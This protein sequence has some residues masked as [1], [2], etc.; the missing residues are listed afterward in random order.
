MA[1]LIGISVIATACGARVAPYLPQGGAGPA[2]LTSD[3]TTTGDGTVTTGGG[4]PNLSTGGGPGGGSTGTGSG[5]TGSTTTT[6]GN[7]GSNTNTNTNTNTNSKPPS[8]IA[9]LTPQNFNFDPQAEA[10][11]CQGTSGNKASDTGIT[12]TSITLGNVSGITGAV[13]GVFEPAVQ[14]VTAAVNAVNHF[15]GIC[16]RKII[17]NIQDDQQSASTHSS[18]IEYLIPKVFAFLGSTSDGDNGGVPAMVKAGIPD[19]GRN[20]NTNRGNAPTFWSAD[21]GSV[22]VRNGR[23]FLYNTLVTGLKKYH[24]MPS[25]M[26]FIAY[27]IPIAAQVAE[28]YAVLFN[29]AGVKTCYTNYSVPPAPGATMGSVVASMKSKGCGGVFVVMDTVGNADLLRDAQ[30]QHWNPKLILTTQGAYT[31]QQIK[32]AGQ[33]AAQ[34]LQVYLPFTPFTETSNPVMRLFQQEMRTYEPGKPVNGFSIE[35]WADAQMFFYA[36]IKAGRNP[37]RES[38]VRELA[39]IKNWTTGG[40]FGPYTPSSRGTAKCYMGAAVK[41]SNWYRVWPPNGGIPCQ[42]TLVD[43]GPA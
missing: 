18:E 39:A 41:G 34:G 28:Q 10:S 9:K 13:S 25:S 16:G 3:G 17:L 2:G 37:T 33:S 29:R 35:S 15:G 43:V 20:A 24:Q 4:N 7:Q 27:G 6:S 36:L 5:T 14:A 8:S 12:P 40:I 21:G 23:S 31:T 42:G 22:V 26:A 38:L 1:A 32:I 11:Y 19:I 30:D